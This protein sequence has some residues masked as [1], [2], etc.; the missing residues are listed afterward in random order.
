MSSILA[1]RIEPKTT[2]T[3]RLLK[4]QRK[5]GHYFRKTTLFLIILAGAFLFTLPFAW[6]VSTAGKDPSLTWKV[7][8]V[9]IPP[10]YKWEN[11]V[12][13]WNMRPFPIFYLNTI[14]ITFM[15]VAGTLISSSLAAFAFARLKF[16][17]RD[18]LFLLVLAVLMLP[19]QVTMIPVFILY[20]KLNLVNTLPSLYLQS[21]FGDA[22]SIFLLRQFFMTIP[23]ELDDA[24]RIDGASKFGV[25]LR[26]L[27]P[28]AR[29][30]L[31][32]VAIFQFTFMW[33][34]FFRPL[35]YINDLKLFPVALAL[36]L[37][38]DETRIDLQFIMAQTVI[39]IIPVLFLFFLAQ[40]KFIQGIVITGVKG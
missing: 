11:Y 22:F 23:L 10:D 24:A 37:F 35:L 13:S 12:I 26:I 5:T 38:Q 30:A 21:W 33:N 39:F 1:R 28:L 31:A 3:D 25:F 9:W 15:S 34:N 7:P 6:M 4:L 2:R 17:A 40:Q 16:P 14:T 19:G 18:V 27:L 8:P 20:S 29:P 36:R 32:V